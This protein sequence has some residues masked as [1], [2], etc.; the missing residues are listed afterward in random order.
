MIVNGR[1][2]PLWS[3]FVERKQEWIDGE[4]TDYGDSLNEALGFVVEPMTTTIT[5]IT[6]KPNGKDSAFFRVV[7]EDFSCG[8]DVKVGSITV[9]DNGESDIIFYGYGGH[10]W[11]MSNAL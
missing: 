11:K 5:D 10:R 9:D 8:F 1:E 6:L 4:L 7:G 2:Y 3:Q